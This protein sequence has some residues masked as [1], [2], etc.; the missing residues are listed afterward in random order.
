MIPASTLVYDIE[1]STRG[2]SMQEKELHQVRFFG[3]YSYKYNQYFFLDKSEKEKIQKLIDEHK[4]LVGFNNLDYDNFVLQNCGFNLNYKLNIDLLKGI[5]DRCAL[6]KFK[7]SILAYHLPG[8]TLDDVTKVLGLADKETG[9]EKIDY[10]LFNKDILTHEEYEKCKSYTLKDIEITKKLYE[11]WF[12]LFN[13]WGHHLNESDRN[14]LKHLSCS[15]S[16][17]TYKVICNRTGMKEEYSDNKT[18]SK[19][20]DGAYVAFPAG[21]K[22]EGDIFCLDF[23]SLYTHIMIQ[24]NL[25]GRNKLENKGWHGT[26][27]F[28]ALGYYNDKEMSKVSQVLHEIYI[29]RKALKKAGDPREMGLKTALNTAYGILRNS[30]FKNVYDDVAGNDCCRIGQYWIKLARRKFKEAGYDVLYTD[31]DSIYIKDLFNNKEKMLAVKNQLMEEI[32]AFVPFPKDT[33]DMDIDYEIEMLHF[34][35]RD[36]KL[37]A[38]EKKE[39]ED[40]DADIEDEDDMINREKGLMKK[41]YLFVYKKKDGSKGVYIKN[42]GIVKRTNTRL[43]KKIFWD[44]MVPTMISEHKVKFDNKDIDSWILSYVQEDLSCI[45]KRFSINNVNNY[46]NN[47]NIYVQ[48]HNYVPKGEKNCLGPGIHHLIPNKR[49]GVGKGYPKYCT[50]KEF[51]ELTIKDLHLET[52]RRELR[53]FNKDYKPELFKPKKWIPF[54]KRSKQFDLFSSYNKCCVVVSEN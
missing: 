39:I 50:I 22:F 4:F 23:A 12:Q 24:C 7:D 42:L 1:T 45:T 17:Y 15:P 32:K 11:W 28:T 13:D 19:L 40:E 16:V 54:R 47:S 27:E 14:K 46:K 25:Y 5:M 21:E 33:F 20:T 48:V 29:E 26:D 51:K 18:Y 34:F 10:E 8:Y 9:K 52:V 37:D 35:F 44:I 38:S 30:L 43:S 53:Y 6:I 2:A 49:F 31:T 36:N 3:A 41:N